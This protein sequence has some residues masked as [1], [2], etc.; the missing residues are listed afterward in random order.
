MDKLPYFVW[1][2]INLWIPHKSIIPVCSGEKVLLIAS[3]S[4][5]VIAEC[6]YSLNGKTGAR[7]M[8]Q[9]VVF[10]E[11]LNL[12]PIIYILWLKTT[13]KSNSRGSDALF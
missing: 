1:E 11:G 7:E 3:G 2:Q 4:L 12:V 5:N 13:F 10:L 6:L 8:A 9:L